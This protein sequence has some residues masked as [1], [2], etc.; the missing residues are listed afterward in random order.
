MPVADAPAGEL[1]VSELQALQGE[2]A[3]LMTGMRKLQLQLRQATQAADERTSLLQAKIEE[4]EAQNLSRAL[5]IRQLE[6][7]NEGLHRVVEAKAP[8]LARVIRERNDALKELS[9]AHK[10]IE[11]LLS[12]Q[13]AEEAPPDVAT[14]RASK[15]ITLAPAKKLQHPQREVPVESDDE[16]TIRPA[17]SVASVSIGPVTHAPLTRTNA[18]NNQRTVTRTSS[19]ETNVS[20]S[21]VADSP[22]NRK[23]GK[24]RLHWYLEFEKCPATSVSHGPIPFALL[25]DRLVLDD[26]MIRSIWSLEFE[27]GYDIRVH[28]EADTAFVYRPVILESLSATYL[29]GW[30]DAAMVRKVQEWSNGI[31]EVNLFSYPAKE[32][33]ESGWF[34]LGK[35]KL[36]YTPVKSIWSKLPEEDTE[37]L[38]AEL[39]DRNPD[40]DA[41]RFRRDVM[42]GKLVQCCIQL[43]NV[44]NKVESLEFLKEYGL[45]PG[46]GRLA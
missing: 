2:L 17:R 9:N 32:D 27:S 16:S 39:K 7:E 31:G 26:D 30:G 37:K 19:V 8:E 29:I 45:L 42:E 33:S 35:H 25:A 3:G 5:E 6:Q 14:R 1:P 13:E 24:K 22:K 44:G 43:E 18:V 36:T 12:H 34:Y 21:S 10:F 4:L 41:S 20:T 28:A 38:L 15:Q 23:T 46:D 40:M 11:D